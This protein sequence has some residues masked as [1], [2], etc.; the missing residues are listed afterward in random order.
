MTD[1]PIANPSKPAPADRR[2][3]VLVLSNLRGDPWRDGAAA[4]DTA[5]DR[6]LLARMLAGH[7]IDL[8][9][10]DPLA[11]P[12]N[13]WG[14]SH[15]L[16]AGLDPVRGLGVLLAERS[17]D[18][19]VSIFESGAVVPLLLRRALR[20]RPPI[21][22]WDVGFG[23]VWRTRQA[24]L[25]FVLPRVDGLFALTGHQKAAAERRY[26]LRAEPEVIGYAVDETFFRPDPSREAG[27][28]LSVGEDGGRDYPTLIAALGD[29]PAPA[30]IKTRQAL[31]LAPDQAGRTRVIAERL[32]YVALRDLY[33]GA[34]VVAVPVHERDNPTGIT[35]IYEAMATGRA[36]VASDVA[37][38]R[39]IVTDGETGL[40]VPVGDP[41]AMRAA[42]A[43]LLADPARR[44]ALGQAARG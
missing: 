37:M 1:A 42:I 25:D 9:E 34:A 16:F 39:E 14:R 20:F 15:P 17:A 36:I 12:L 5:P 30:V 13:P 31:A 32:S 18:L 38:M 29:I 10:R 8:I 41:A 2:L 35:A 24:V 4:P 40:L 6:A 44:A 22:L 11:P 27:Y 19:I 3:R 7:G 28:V 26:R 21:V 33:Q 23:G 43:G